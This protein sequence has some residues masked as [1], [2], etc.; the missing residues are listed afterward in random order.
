MNYWKIGSRWHE[1]GDKGKSILS[2]FRRYNIV[3]AK[4]KN[5]ARRILKEVKVGDV[6][7]IADGYKI[8]DI[9]IVTNIPVMLNAFNLVLSKT[10]VEIFDYNEEKDDT[11]AVEVEIYHCDKPIVYK[12]QSKFCKINDQNVINKINAILGI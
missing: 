5:G 11:E 9:G 10:E 2:I 7:A 3:F 1:H 8:E 4:E 6:I 12:K